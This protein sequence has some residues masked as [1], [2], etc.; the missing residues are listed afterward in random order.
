[1]FR[2]PSASDLVLLRQCAAL[3]DKKNVYGLAIEARL[4]YD[5]ITQRWEIVVMCDRGR[6]RK[7][8]L[9]VLNRA[10]DE[11]TIESALFLVNEAIE[12]KEKSA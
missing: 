5:L 4:S 7:D 9:L 6:W 10:T 1:M 12:K 3:L 8:I 2:I 11:S